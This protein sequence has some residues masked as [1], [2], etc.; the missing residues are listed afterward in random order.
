MKN[1]K[2][3]KLFKN[4][5]TCCFLAF[6]LASS[7]GLLHAQSLDYGT[8][9][10]STI[11]EDAVQGII[12][13][14]S[15]IISDSFTPMTHYDKEDY[16]ITLVP[17]YFKINKL[18]DDRDIQGEDLKGYAFGFGGGYA[19]NNR[20]MVYGI[21]TGLKIN[22][23]A[24]SKE[25]PAY[26]ADVEYGMFTLSAGIGFDLFE[27]GKWSIP[28]YLGMCLQRYDAEIIPPQFAYMS[29]NAKVNVTGQG[30]LY[31]P[32]A[33]IAVSREFFDLVRITPYLLMLWNINKPDLTA[34]ARARLSFPAGTAKR[35]YDLELESVK[36]QML[37]LNITYISSDSFS[38]SLSAGGLLTSSTGCYNEKFLDGLNMM[39]IVLAVS[40]SQKGS[41]KI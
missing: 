12:N 22:G 25:F 7:Y 34:E 8:Y 39:S 4:F 19:V 40:Y 17:A 33:A 1:E 41:Q 26:R 9:T 16:V 37:G 28:F 3:T 10:E 5:L 18:F 29:V 31:G 32:T 24:Y 36:A 6:I 14:T 11:T 35:T 2:Q 20:L 21:F 13:V 30:L 27:K 38:V 15:S 23:E